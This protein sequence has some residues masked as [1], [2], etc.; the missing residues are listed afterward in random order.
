MVNILVSGKAYKIQAFSSLVK[1]PLFL[2]RVKVSLFFSKLDEE[3]AKRKSE[4]ACR[5]SKERVFRGQVSERINLSDLPSWA[6]H[7]QQS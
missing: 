4:Q 6:L 3:L 7:D 5:Q 1:G 2:G